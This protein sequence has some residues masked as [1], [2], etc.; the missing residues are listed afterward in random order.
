MKPFA[1]TTTACILLI[2]LLQLVGCGGSTTVA[3]GGGISGTGAQTIAIGQVTGY[4]S[5]FVGGT[6]YFA[7]TTSGLPASKIRFRFDN[8]STA[9]EIALKL[10][11]SVSV[12]GGFNQ[13]ASRFEYTAIDYRPELRGPLT[14]VNS[15]VGTLT[16]L[17]R[18][19]HVDSKT[20]FDGGILT[21][22]D[23]A[24]LTGTT[25]VEVNGNI[26]ANGMIL[27][28]RVALINSS[29]P[30]GGPVQLKGAISTIDSGSISIGNQLIDL[31]NAT[32]S[33]MQLA[34]LK[35]GLFV[36][37]K[38]ALRNGTIV[39]P[40]IEKKNA[41]NEVRPG[42]I[43]EMLGVAQGSAPANRIDMAGPDGPVKLVITGS[44]AFRQNGGIVDQ[45][46]ILPGSI[47]E[48]KGALQSDG[49]LIASRVSIE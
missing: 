3:G 14:A 22:S 46:F 42:E 25:E 1:L 24:A 29:F 47:L 11:M 34:D 30:P 48:V 23:L 27:A 5:I 13:T 32:F 7:S 8:T 9:Q 19:A 4:G 15:A 26:N 43:L 44:T 41:V 2:S 45:S 12:K 33:N 35:T 21:L 18:S 40:R 37:V 31:Q 39:T 10:G 36:E 38:G 28:S 16:I 20:R 49:S 17:G 6:E